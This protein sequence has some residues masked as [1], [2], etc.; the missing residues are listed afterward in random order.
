MLY[1]RRMPGDERQSI[2]FFEAP[3]EVKGTGFLA[4][5]HK[6]RPAEQ[7]LYLP[8]LQRVRQISRRSRN[9]S[10]VG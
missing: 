9:E 8:A 10:F 5:T 2:V 6:S 4:Y 1:E 7:W 3:A